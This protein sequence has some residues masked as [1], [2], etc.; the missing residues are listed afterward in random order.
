MEFDKEDLIEK[1]FVRSNY[2]GKSH[3]L[4][5]RDLTDMAKI[6]QKVCH[7]CLLNKPG[8]K[9]ASWDI[10]ALDYTT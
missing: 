10:I 5:Y 8:S 4:I 1:T 3:K 2:K 9:N 7:K 6:W